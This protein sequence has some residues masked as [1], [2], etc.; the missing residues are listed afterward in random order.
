MWF[1]IRRVDPDNMHHT[2]Y[3][4]ILWTPAVPERDRT[5]YYTSIRDHLQP[6]QTPP[7]LPSLCPTYSP[8]TW[9]VQFLSIMEVFNISLTSS[10][11][12][13]GCRT[14]SKRALI[15]VD[16][17]NS[18][19]GGC[20]IGRLGGVN[21]REPGGN[22]GIVGRLCG[23]QRVRCGAVSLGFLCLA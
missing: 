5:G 7:L 9:Q 18:T 21:T 12:S 20:R 15:L 22:V 23:E 10:V 1:T 19:P 11:R 16:F 13:A 6:S 4:R 3:L 17:V 2:R 14:T 8:N